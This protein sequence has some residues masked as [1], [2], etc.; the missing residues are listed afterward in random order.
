MKTRS[1]PG[2]VGMF[3]LVAAVAV[4]L[5]THRVSAQQV[6]DGTEPA[7]EAIDDGFRPVWQQKQ[8][9][10]VASAQKSKAQ[11][12]AQQL[13]ANQPADAAHTETRVYDRWTVTCRSMENEKAR[14]ACSAALRIVN[15]QQQLVILWEIGRGADGR[16]RASLQTPTGVM[17][18]K[19]VDLKVGEARVGKFDYAACV[20]QNCEAG[21]AMDGTQIKKMAAAS[22]MTITIHA[23]DGRDVNFKFP[24]KGLDK[25]MTAVGS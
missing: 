22:E 5:M 16:I 13:A 25:A 19:G 3:T 9:K 2:T 21:G 20:P 15:N 23:R 7:A 12:A 1:R 24:M 10:P 8:I 17:V 4:L 14:R 18:Q 11:P 6:D